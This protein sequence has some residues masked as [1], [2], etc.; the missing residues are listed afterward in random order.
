MRKT[1][2]GV[3]IVCGAAISA[4]LLF[5]G[6]AGMSFEKNQLAEESPFMIKNGDKVV[7]YGDSI[8]DDQWYPTFIRTF[9]ATRHPEWRNTFLNRG[10]SGDRTSSLERF[11]RD[12]VEQ[13]PDVALF[14]MGY[15]DLRYGKLSSKWLET[16]LGNVEE[17]ILMLR[18]RSPK[19]KL[20]LVSSPLNETVVSHEPCWVSPKSY[21]YALLILELCPFP[22]THSRWVR[23]LIKCSS[24]CHWEFPPSVH[25]SG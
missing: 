6:C 25:R 17:S 21:P 10:V 11:E 18:A 7:F 1:I 16:F 23:P 14:M 2:V 4:G 12:V 5:A 8:T 13:K 3:I 19:T 22:K 15:N 24:I 20:L 9:V